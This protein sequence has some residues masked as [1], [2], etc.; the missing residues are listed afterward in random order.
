MV[1]KIT[2]KLVVTGYYGSKLLEFIEKPFDQV[3]LTVK[4][5]LRFSLC[6]SVSF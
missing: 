2:F 3:S 5:Q 1:E 6:C 4:N